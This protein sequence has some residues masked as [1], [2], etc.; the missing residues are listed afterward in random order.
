M[1][2]VVIVLL[3]LNLLM[4]AVY[5]NALTRNLV[6]LYNALLKALRR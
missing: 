1:I 6:E 5:A 2:W 4:Q 3:V